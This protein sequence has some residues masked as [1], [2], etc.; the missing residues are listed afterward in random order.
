MYKHAEEMTLYAALK[1]FV[2][3]DRVLTA[4]SDHRL[5]ASSHA[6]HTRLQ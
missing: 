4:V 5:Q 6:D 3:A 2:D 1:T